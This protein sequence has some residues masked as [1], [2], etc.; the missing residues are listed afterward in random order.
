MFLDIG[1]KT[2]ALYVAIL[3]EARTVFWN[4]PLGLFENPAYA[5]GSRVVAQAIADCE[6]YSVI[7][8]GDT[9]VVIDQ[10]GLKGQVSHLSTGGGASLAFLAKKELPGLAALE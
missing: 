1:P 3:T 7:G 8:G 4:G 10:F 2:R 6:G 5:E 9:E